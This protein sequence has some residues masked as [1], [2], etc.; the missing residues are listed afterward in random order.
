[1]EHGKL[2]GYLEVR[3]TATLKNWQQAFLKDMRI[4]SASWREM[5][6]TCCCS[7]PW[8]FPGSASSGKAGNI[9]ALLAAYSSVVEYAKADEL[10]N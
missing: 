1:M 4:I 10:P 2:P 3:R 7:E 6:I 9:A 8:G 5:I